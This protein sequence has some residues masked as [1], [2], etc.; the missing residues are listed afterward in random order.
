M[1]ARNKYLIF[2]APHKTTYLNISPVLDLLDSSINLI[3]ICQCNFYKENKKMCEIVKDEYK[4]ITYCLKNPFKF[5]KYY[6]PSILQKIFV[7]LYLKIF[8]RKTIK[9][10]I[11]YI[12]C[13]GG[14]V[15]ATVAKSVY[16]QGKKAIMIEGGFPLDLINKNK[17]KFYQKIF[18]KLFINHSINNP[19]KYVSKLIVAGDFSKELR[20]KNGFET[21]KIS[22]LGVP[23]NKNLFYV[24][25]KTNRIAYDI[26]FLTGSFKFHGDVE[27]YLMQS[28][29]VKNLT[30]YSTLNKI[31]L[32]IQVHPRDPEDYKV[33]KNDFVSFTHENLVSNIQSSKI[34]LSFYSTAVYESLLLNTDAYFVGQQL[35]NYW[36]END[37]LMDQKN[38]SKLAQLLNEGVKENIDSK[39][40]IAYN[41][42]SKD[43]VSSAKK[44]KELILEDVN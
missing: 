32:L 8:L 5:K 28:K 18:A 3:Y 10:A 11:S 34:C 43:S 26:I 27:N 31:K 20:I 30:E 19:L 33:Y 14:L 35:N 17:H 13:P 1:K 36:P 42:I 21:S 23:R 39:K 37:F 16:K 22:A 25:D 9:L 7:K 15:E 4:I 29:Y 40:N 38:F 2:S 24:Q 6:D 44:I 41:H 12:F